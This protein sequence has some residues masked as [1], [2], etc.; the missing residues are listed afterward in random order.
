MAIS[1]RIDKNR[2]R[3]TYPFIRRVP[4][5]S[6]ELDEPMI[7]ETASVTFSATDEVTYTFTEPFTAAP[8]VTLTAKSD[9]VN[10]YISAVSASSVT[11]N[12]SAAF[13]GSVELHAIQIG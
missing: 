7:I 8:H 2:R 5:Y 13:T 3:K 10:I 6:Y 1:K 12:A 4:V 9:N 11:I